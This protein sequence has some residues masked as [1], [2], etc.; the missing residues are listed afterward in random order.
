M[1]CHLFYE[2][3]AE[4][5]FAILSGVTVVTVTLGQKKPVNIE[6]LRRVNTMSRELYIPQGYK[7]K[8][9]LRETQHAIKYIK[10][11]FQQALSFA[12]SVR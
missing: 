4:N 12:L 7:S 3:K 2:R 6:L 8:L 1:T 11:V 5:G 9:T 10:D